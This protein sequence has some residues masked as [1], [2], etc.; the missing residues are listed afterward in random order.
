MTDNTLNIVSAF[1]EGG[2]SPVWVN[3]IEH[4]CKSKNYVS[5]ETVNNELKK[6]NTKLDNTK[7]V[8]DTAQDKMLFVL[9]WA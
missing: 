1:H 3:F 6:Y 2:F 7:L 9:R 8:F 5:V 4:F